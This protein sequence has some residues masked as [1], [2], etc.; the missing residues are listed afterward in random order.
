MDNTPLN[1]RSHHQRPTRAEVIAGLLAFI[2]RR[3]REAGYAALTLSERRE[4]A[5][6]RLNPVKGSP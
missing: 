1:G 4:I 6:D 3:L 5:L 2:D